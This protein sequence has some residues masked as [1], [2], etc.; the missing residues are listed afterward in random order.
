[1][2][3]SCDICT[4]EP[5]ITMVHFTDDRD[6]HHS[7]YALDV[8]EAA[9]DATDLGE[10]LWWSQRA[11][12]AQDWLRQA[13]DAGDWQGAAAARRSMAKRMGMALDAKAR[14]LVAGAA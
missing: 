13:S 1:M 3:C 14:Y 11:V 2:P 6:A 10:W 7:A 5:D 4:M 12:E 9:Q 8:R